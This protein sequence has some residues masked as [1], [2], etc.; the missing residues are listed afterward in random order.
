[1]PDTTYEKLV[2][3]ILLEQEIRR[4]L[5]MKLSV[6]ETILAHQDALI[7]QLQERERAMTDMQKALGMRLQAMNE[8][9]ERAEREKMW[10]VWAS[11]GLGVLLVLSLLL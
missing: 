10:S 2:H 8:Q 4:N 6:C 5:I 9:V 7:R 11:I 3:R 1:M